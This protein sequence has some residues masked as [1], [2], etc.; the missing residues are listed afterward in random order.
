MSR[1]PAGTAITRLEV[2]GIV[3]AIAIRQGLVAADRARIALSG[4][5]AWSVE[6]SFCHHNPT[7]NISPRAQISARDRVLTEAE[8]VEVWSAC[9]DND[10]GRIVRLLILTGQ[11]R[12]EIGDLM[13]TELNF[14][15]RQIELPAARV[16]NGKAHLV[17]LSDQALTTLADVEHREGRDFIFG[18]GEGGFS[19]WSKAKAEL[20]ARIAAARK[21]AVVKRPMLPWVLHDLR[22]SFVTHINENKIAPPHVVEAIVN[23]ISGHLAGVAGTYNKALYLEERRSALKTWGQHFATLIQRRQRNVV[24]K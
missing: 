7:L 19:G 13:W 6:R 14:E 4:F 5:Y 10:H 9:N 21:A 18:R 1:L 24:A 8:L 3:D 23:H 17:P 12:Q 15:E 22:R 2:V 16:K 11:R 20:D